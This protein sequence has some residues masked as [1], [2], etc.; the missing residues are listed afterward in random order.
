MKPMDDQ[1]KNR[2]L[3]VTFP[4]I[5]RERDPDPP[6]DPGEPPP[7]SGQKCGNCD[8]FAIVHHPVLGPETI[9][10]AEPPKPICLG[11]GQTKTVN[12]ATGQPTQFPVIQGFQPPT[13]PEA[14]CRAWQW[15][16]PVKDE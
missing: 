6:F 13:S 9:C 7:R 4:P 10:A 3:R 11:V 15:S 2:D 8:A 16:G 1:R 12:A 5:G 14:W